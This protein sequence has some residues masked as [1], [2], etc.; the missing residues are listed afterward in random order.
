M[1]GGYCFVV[2]VIEIFD[3]VSGKRT[4]RGVTLP[5]EYETVT[6]VPRHLVD[7][8]LRARNALERTEHLRRL[9]DRG[10]LICGRG[11]LT[12][13]VRDLNDRAYVFRGQAAGVPRIRPH[14]SRVRFL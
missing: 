3:W 11:R 12:Q 2:S 14:R 6:V 4:C 5:Y 9:R 8:F 1:A 13:N 7:E 10:L